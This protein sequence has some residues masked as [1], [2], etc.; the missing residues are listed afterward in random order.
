[1]YKTT[2]AGEVKANRQV[3]GLRYPSL[4]IW[5][6]SVVKVG[7]VDDNN[8]FRKYAITEK[9]CNEIRITE[10]YD[11][12]ATQNKICKL[13]YMNLSNEMQETEVPAEMLAEKNK[14]VS[15]ASKGL[16]INSKNAEMV[17]CHLN[18]E[19]RKA[20]SRKH[21]SRVGIFETDNK[22]FYVGDKTIYKI[23]G[24]KGLKKSTIKYSG[25]LDISCRGDWKVYK[26]MIKQDVVPS[27]CM[28]TA[29][30]IGASAPVVSYIG[31]QVG[32]SNLLVHFCGDS[33]T[34]KST[35]LQL[36]LSVFSGR[37]AEEGKI[38]IFS[39]WNSTPNAIQELFVDNY[40][41]SMGLDE[42]GMAINKEFGSLIYRL[43]EGTEKSRMSSELKNKQ[44]RHWH[45]TIISTGEIPLEAGIDRATGQK[46][47]LLNFEGTPWTNSAEHSDRITDVLNENYGFLGNRIAKKLLSEE[48]DYWIYRHK[49]EKEYIQPKLSCGVLDARIANQLAI[50]TLA[51]HILN[52]VSIDIDSNMVTELL[53]AVANDTMG[54]KKSIG[55]EAFEKLK[56]YITTNQN[57]IEIRSDNGAKIIKEVPVGELLGVALVKTLIVNPHGGIDKDSFSF[58]EVA[59][60][61]ETVKK[62]LKDNGYN[63][64]DTIYSHWKSAG[65]LVLTKDKRIVHKLKIGTVKDSKCVKIK[66]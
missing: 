45:T 9:I 54:S 59:I 17:I 66:L 33:T 21:T 61:E 39:T 41:I 42:A 37:K 25:N 64:A 16:D 27:V 63:N 7:L 11:D 57:R 53:V 43:V 40:G 20:T 44:V 51:A 3:K 31:S 6:D 47:R 8:G 15:L 49:I 23:K 29:L 26:N 30:A 48:Q 34:G 60:Q 10:I 55:E 18:N 38:S 28:S 32:V 1:M 46:V 56:E 5:E 14:L 50:I 4:I 12:I 36:A 62:F 58:S 35:S 65:H 19:M 52:E 13:S 2:L 24:E 22:I